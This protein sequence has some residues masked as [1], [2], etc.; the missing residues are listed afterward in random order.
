MAQKREE[1]L[2]ESLSSEISLPPPNRQDSRHSRQGQIY[3][4][5]V[6][7]III[8]INAQRGQLVICKRSDRRRR[9]FTTAG[10]PYYSKRSN[11]LGGGGG[12]S[13]VVDILRGQTTPLYTSPDCY[14]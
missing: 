11:H 10:Q 2:Q 14:Y 4:L 7:I 8:I 3:D 5:L 12:L 9:Q 13:D 1:K 6:I